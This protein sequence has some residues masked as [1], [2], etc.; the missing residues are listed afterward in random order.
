MKRQS[1]LADQLLATDPKQEF[2]IDKKWS[3]ARIASLQTAK[4]FVLDTAATCY[5]AEMIRDYPRIIADAQDFAIPPFKNMWIEMPYRLFYET[6]TGKIAAFDSDHVVGYLFDGP[7]VVSAA[8]IPDKVPSFVP[9]EYVLH[10]EMGLNEQ[11]RLSD[12]LGI[13]RIGL[14]AFFWGSTTTHWTHTSTIS[15]SEEAAKTWDTESLRALRANH[16]IRLVKLGDDV[17]RDIYGTIFDGSAGDLRNIVS[18]LLYLNRTQDIQT[19]T[20]YGHSHGAIRK[21]IKPWVAHSVVSLKLNPH[22]RFRKLVADRTGV[23]RRLHDVR[24]HFCHD[25]KARMG[26]QHGIEQTGDFG[27]WW[28]EYEP[29]KWKCTT[30]GGKRWWRTEHSRGHFVEGIVLQQYAVTK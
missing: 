30:C 19:V 9:I 27:D 2:R 26:C 21:K 14:D 22:P 1:L 4:K 5:L 7:L 8:G 13:S 24:G 16:T 25:K 29:L 17:D 11:I 20:Q 10:R 28:Q 18:L 15:D 12:A 23:Q 6:L 3:A